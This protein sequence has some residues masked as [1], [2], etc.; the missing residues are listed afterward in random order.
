MSSI[1]LT[2]LLVGAIRTGE[3][4]SID[5]VNELAT[6]VQ[7]LGFDERCA[8]ICASADAE[9]IARGQRIGTHD[10]Q[11]AATA[12]AYGLTLVTH[13]TAEFSRVSNLQIADW[14]S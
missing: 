6:R 14:Q 3:S 5:A 13:N 7:I 9:L 4:K 8:R 2:E 12:L 1:V 11:I 10:I